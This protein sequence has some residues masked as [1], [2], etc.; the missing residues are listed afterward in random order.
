MKTNLN[1]IVRG[2]LFTVCAVVL[3]GLTACA[4]LF[5][6]DEHENYECPHCHLEFQTQSAMHNHVHDIHDNKGNHDKQ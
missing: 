6:H 3:L 2:M 1:C 5:H 4:H